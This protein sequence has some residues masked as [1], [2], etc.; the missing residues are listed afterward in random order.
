MTVKVHMYQAAFKCW[1]ST[2]RHAILLNNLIAIIHVLWC[3]MLIP[4]FNIFVIATQSWFYV[5]QINVFL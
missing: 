3:K 1:F 5:Q 2:Q 4:L